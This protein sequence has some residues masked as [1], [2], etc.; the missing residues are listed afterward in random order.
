M[1]VETAQFI[2]NLNPA[3]P[4]GAS[5]PITEGDNHI[6]LIKGAILATFPTIAGQVAATHADLSSLL[7]AATTGANGL[8]V[9]TQAATNNGTLA[10]STAQVQGAIG[11]AIAPLAP[12]NS[13]AFTGTPIAPT[14]TPG[15]A[16]GQLATTA[17]AAALNIVGTAAAT[18]SA[19]AS[20][21][22]ATAAAASA[23]ISAGAVIWVTGS[24]YAVNAR[25]ISPSNGRVYMSLASVVSNTDPASDTRWLLVTTNRVA[26]AITAATI[27]AISGT[28]YV[29]TNA[30]QSI[31]TLPATPVTGSVVQVTFANARTDNIVA[32]NGSAL[33]LDSAGNP[34]FEDLIVDVLNKTLILEYAG[35]AWRFYIDSSSVATQLLFNPGA[36]AIT[37][38]ILSG[39]V[40][41]DLAASTGAGLVGTIASVT[42]AVARTQQD[43]N[44]DFVSVK[45]AGAIGNGANDTSAALQKQFTLG[46]GW[47]IPQGVYKFSTGLIA[48]Y[49]INTFPAISFPSIRY[50]VTGDAMANTLLEFSGIGTA[51][52]SIGSGTTLGEG[53]HSFDRLANFSLYPTG[54]TQTQTG[55][56]FLR[57]AYSTIEN[58]CIDYFTN[59]LVLDGCLTSTLKNVHVRNNTDG[60]ILS[61]TTGF[62]RPNALLWERVTVLNNIRHGVV[63]NLIGAANQFIGLNVEQNGRQGIAGEGGFIG[64]LIGDNGIASVSFDAC[65]FEGNGGDADLYLTNPTSANITVVLKS[66]VFNRTSSAKYTKS[67]IKLVNS[68]G[69]TIRC[70]LIG[71]GFLSAGS[72]LPSS[73]N[74]FISAD[75]RCEVIDIGCTYSEVIS[76]ASIP[77]GKIADSLT[78]TAVTGTATTIYTLPNTTKAALYSVHASIGAVSDA[79]NFGASATVYTDSG[80][81]RMVNINNGALQT[82]SLSGMSVQST[83]TS[84]VNQSITVSVTRLA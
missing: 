83:Q 16:T 29:M 80:T 41:P 52:T 58:V 70:I 14:A 79:T 20:A 62:S 13:P 69:G 76:K 61:D 36:V 25:V 8:N 6:R 54:R 15:T 35:N 74:P 84:G 66:C 18:A 21:S 49:S 64:N 12:I 40:L 7:G 17:F 81:A 24:T 46:G 26:V 59:G 1:T 28:H 60:I 2:N 56:S 75:S 53:V 63:A 55:I 67:N 50:D 33:L 51:I 42:G 19:T 5:D 71:C 73:A 11:L 31:L 10:A 57:K 45:D 37:G 43:K 22:T 4:N 30:G 23:A 38:G 68:G 34:L 39:V 77:M 72:Y 48:D 82:I 3:L 9:V 65:Y 44:S 27:T 47:H 32:R 78:A